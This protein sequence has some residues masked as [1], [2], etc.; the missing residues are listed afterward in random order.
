MQS[1][2]LFSC[3]FFS[4]TEIQG[5]ERDKAFQQTA[6]NRIT[7]IISQRYNLSTNINKLINNYLLKSEN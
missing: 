3:L 7:K 5:C 1:H 4:S 2:N 6:Y